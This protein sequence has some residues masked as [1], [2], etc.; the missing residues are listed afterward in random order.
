MD[1]IFYIIFLKII[2]IKKNNNDNKQRLLSKFI[3][4]N[5]FYFNMLFQITTQH[6]TAVPDQDTIV[7]YNSL[8]VANNI[9]QEY[10]D[11]ASYSLF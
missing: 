2:L 1:L 4:F 11:H 10:L 5:I 9:Q 7:I 6:W 3:C 8:L